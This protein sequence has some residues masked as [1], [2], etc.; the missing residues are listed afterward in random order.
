M[1]LIFSEISH[2]ALGHILP[3]SLCQSAF[4]LQSSM[5]C[6]LVF[7]IRTLPKLSNINFKDEGDF[8]PPVAVGVG[9]GP[10][11]ED[12]GECDLIPVAIY[13][14]VGRGTGL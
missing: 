12:R 7:R 3:G 13:S 5:K 4:H 6:F 2:Q 11:I 9:N 8:Y 14:D 10:T 1:V